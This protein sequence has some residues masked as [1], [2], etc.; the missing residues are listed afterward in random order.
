MRCSVCK[1]SVSDHILRSTCN[2]V[3]LNSVIRN[4]NLRLLNRKPLIRFEK[5]F[6]SLKR[7]LRA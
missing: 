2:N 7:F 1:R 4:L 6:E 3:V 5:L